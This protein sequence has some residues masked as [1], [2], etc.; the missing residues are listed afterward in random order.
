MSNPIFDQ[1]A[2]Q[3]WRKSKPHDGATAVKQRNIE[4]STSFTSSL[5]LCTSNPINNTNQNSPQPQNSTAKMVYTLVVHLY[6]KDDA[7]SI[8]KLV[9]KLQEASQVYSNDK[10][11]L[12]WWV[13]LLPWMRSEV[14]GRN[15]ARK[16]LTSRALQWQKRNQKIHQS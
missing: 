13:E 1:A 11:T 7:E 9:A 5:E 8:S 3:Q 16:A 6:A 2:L 10:E 4:P 14:K 15:W 12:G